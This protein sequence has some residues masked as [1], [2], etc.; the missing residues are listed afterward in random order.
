MVDEDEVY[1]GSLAST[2]QRLGVPLIIGI[3]VAAVALVSFVFGVA[4]YM[5]KRRGAGKGTSTQYEVK[6]EAPKTAAAPGEASERAEESVIAPLPGN[7]EIMPRL[8]YEVLMRLPRE[9]RSRS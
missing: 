1:G 2:A 4:L 6:V 7:D 8:S 3:V 5:I 9:P